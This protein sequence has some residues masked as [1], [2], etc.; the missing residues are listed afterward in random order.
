M[1]CL[2]LNRFSHHLQVSFKDLVFICRHWY[3]LYVPN[4]FAHRRKFK[5]TKVSDSLLLDS[6]IWQAKTEIESQ[7]RF[8]ECFGGLSHSRFNRHSRQLLTVIYQIRHKMNQKVDLGGQF[9]ILDSFPVPAWQPIRNYCAK[10]FRG[11]ADIGYKATKKIYYL[12]A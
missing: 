10:S 5:H 12:Y 9:L 7:R 2:N 6:L 8:C 3:R 11:Y 1:N 4:K